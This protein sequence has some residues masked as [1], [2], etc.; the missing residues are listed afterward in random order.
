MMSA[1][2]GAVGGNSR[3]SVVGLTGGMTDR[4]CGMMEGNILVGDRGVIEISRHL[5]GLRKTT[6]KAQLNNRHPCGD[7]SRVPPEYKKSTA[8]TNSQVECHT[9]ASN[10]D[11]WTRDNT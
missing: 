7:S 3:V 6:I 8:P 2:T 9:T 1:V 11:E 10:G 5:N 4:N